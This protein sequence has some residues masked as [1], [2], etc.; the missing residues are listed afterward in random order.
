MAIRIDEYGHIIRDD[1]APQDSSMI[2]SLS[3]DDDQ[4]YVPNNS[5][6]LGYLSGIRLNEPNE[7]I[8]N[9][10]STSNNL[11]DTRDVNVASIPRLETSTPWYSGDIVF[12]TITMLLSIAVALVMSMAVAPQIFETDWSSS[13]FLE[14]IEKFLY[15]IAPYGVFVGTFIGSIWYNSAGTKKSGRYYHVAYEYL[16]STLCSIAGAVGSGV[17]IFLLALSIYIIAAIAIIGLI[18]AIVAGLL[19]G[20]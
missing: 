15:T 3:S 4:L 8:T 13:G 6:S 7:T 11:R 10:I 18:I 17:I 12:W 5:S 16:L 2:Q 1:I 19:S 20:G 9:G 14:S